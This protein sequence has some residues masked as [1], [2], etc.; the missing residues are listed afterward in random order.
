[1]I[2]EILHIFQPI[3]PRWNYQGICYVLEKATG[4]LQTRYKDM[5]EFRATIIPLLLCCSYSNY[6]FRIGKFLIPRS[7]F[8][9]FDHQMRMPVSGSIPISKEIFGIIDTKDFQRL[10]GIRQLG[11]TYFVYPGATHT[12]FE[13]S[14]G[15]YALSLKYLEV[16]LRNENLFNAV[17]GIVGRARGFRFYF[18]LGVAIFA[19]TDSRIQTINRS[20]EHFLD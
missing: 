15:T 14:L 19:A 11:P 5:A 8:C 10:K 4:E 7:R 18:R 17:T 9:Y 3:Y 20:K 16:L 13:H 12:R 1:M 6:E 2:Y